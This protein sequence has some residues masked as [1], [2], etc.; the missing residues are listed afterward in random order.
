MSIIITLS[1]M[2]YLGIPVNVLTSIVPAL[3]IIIGSTE[4]VH[5]LAEYHS[6][7]EKGLSRAESIDGLPRNQSVAILCNVYYYFYRFSVDHSQ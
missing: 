5:L 6:G 2:A 7:I 1:V 3:L 4:D